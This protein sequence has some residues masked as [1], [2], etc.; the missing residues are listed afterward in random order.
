[1]GG[2]EMITIKKQFIRDRKGKAIAVVVDLKTFEEI[3]ELLEDL[4][5]VKII[6]QRMD[7]PDLDWE[8]VKTG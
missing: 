6:E 5:D 3:E 4:N 1:L 7:E 2:D 8:K